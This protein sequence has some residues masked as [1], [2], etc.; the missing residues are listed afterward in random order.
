MNENNSF[1]EKL[2]SFL[3][4]KGFYIV[5]AV[6]V[7]VIA[8]SAWSLVNSGVFSV[9]EPVQPDVSLDVQDPAPKPSGGV[10]SGSDLQERPPEVSVFKPNEPDTAPDADAEPQPEPQPETPPTV[11][12]PASRLSFCLPV[13]GEVISGFSVDE[14]VYS[15]TL[16][17]WR[18]HTGVDF[19]A[20]EGTPVAA[21]ADGTVK[22]VYNDA[23]MGVTMI[24]EHGDGLYSIYSNLS[25]ETA[26][27]EFEPVKGGEIIGTVGATA[28][29]ESGDRCH[30]HFAME[31]DGDVC[32]PF[33]YLPRG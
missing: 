26:L 33:E 28:I 1:G 9:H 7:L 21:V 12:E 29:A 22:R 6:C 14:L 8:F 20:D 4:G 16:A 5:L 11:H 2:E 32:D 15:S 30:L 25:E 17:D 31:K 18:V 13:S 10:I 27:T 23:L 24:V 3:A 19:A